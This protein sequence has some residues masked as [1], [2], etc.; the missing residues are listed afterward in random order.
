MTH[1]GYLLKQEASII[2]EVALEKE[3][4]E[5][6]E[7]YKRSS[8]PKDLYELIDKIDNVVS[9]I[10]N[11]LDNYTTIKQKKLQQDITNIELI[12]A[13]RLSSTITHSNELSQLFQVANDLGH[14]L[15]YKI[16]SLDEEIG[17]VDKTLDFVKNIQLLKNNINQAHYAI[18][19]NNWELAAQ[20]IHKITSNLPRELIDGKFASVVIPSTDIPE[21]PHVAIEK[22]IKKL[23]NVF[24][25]KFNE[26]AQARNVEHL[27][28]YFQLFPMIGQ[29]EIGLNCYS[30]FICEII[31]ETSKSLIS[32]TN[33]VNPDDLIPG[34]FATITMQLFE[35]ISMMLS[36]HGP[37]IKRYYS[38]TYPGALS[39]VIT[40]IQREID[41]QIGIISDTFYD[42][43]RLDKYFQDIS[44][45]NFPILAARQNQLREQS[46]ES[47][48][49][50]EYF[51][52]SME[53]NDNDLVP[54]RHIGDMLSELASIF[55]HWSM[56]CKF[57]TIKYFNTQQEGS[58]LLSLPDLISKSNFTKKINEKLLPSLETLHKFY[59]RRSL[60]KAITI[61]EMPSLDS[62]LVYHPS[63]ERLV[64][65]EQVPCSSVI[66]DLTLILNT[67][68]RNIID[69]GI[70]SSVK[71]FINESFLVIQSDLINGFFIKNLNDNQP[72]Y[73]QTLSLLAAGEG[74]HAASGGPPSPGVSRSSTPDPGAVGMG[75][76]KGAATSAL[77][78]VVS[79]SGAIVGSLQTAPNNP[80]LLNF[81]IY[82]NTVA[83][84]QEYFGKVFDKILKSDQYYLK[85][86]FPF[87]KDKD[88]IETI[89][90]NDFLD[91]FMSITNKIIAESLVNLYNQSIKSKLIALVNEFL[92]ESNENYIIYS[93][94]SLNDP[95]TLL[96]FTANWQALIKPYVQT[97]HKSL[98]FD[99]LLRLIVINLSNLIEKK[100]MVSLKK[101][102][103]N[104]LGSIKLEKDLSYLINQVCAD[105]YPLREKFVRITQIVLLVGMDDEEYDESYQH[106]A[107]SKKIN[108]GDEEDEMDLEENL[109][110]NWVLT[111]Q[112]RNQIRKYRV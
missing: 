14:S 68:L 70:P 106:V 82:L 48:K 71:T 13:T 107:I 62:Y 23:T 22:W 3:V 69:S 56:Y 87:G 64:F 44:L 92:P 85:N 109:G 76:L 45:Y 74:S 96:K 111:P 12:R 98:I 99:K 55:H 49:S 104:E 73:N 79:G 94:A 40:K 86:S 15:T 67:T 19:H 84:A 11:D 77:G 30:K 18:E 53:I 50:G 93:S 83:M 47:R 33:D 108:G 31:N 88:K 66:E 78:S 43:R 39:Y 38:S 26:A 34:V 35:S 54:I 37:L 89:L 95:S 80:K 46:N 1:N 65:P 102:K 41:M 90:K 81:I 20:C 10:D 29:E 8:N 21:L 6:Q 103:I 100:L 7:L 97:C 112:E 75:F 5:I 17:N 24:K 59:F 2:N 110:I 52:T 105:N 16:K 42:M 91:P 4:D 101:F 61:E 27:T 25:D 36:Q 58:E 28:K 32:R 51:D 9:H 72:R 63:P 57:I 60:E